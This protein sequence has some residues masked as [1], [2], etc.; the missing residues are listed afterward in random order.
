MIRTSRNSWKKGRKRRVG[1]LEH[2]LPNLTPTLLSLAGTHLLQA[3]GVQLGFVDDFD[4]NLEVK[5]AGEG[6]GTPTQITW[7]VLPLPQLTEKPQPGPFLVDR[8]LGL[9]TFAHAVPTVP[10]ATLTF[11]RKYSYSAVRL[12]GAAPGACVSV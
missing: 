10:N 4:G 3:A 9:R 1:G 2:P 11:I 5:E 8:D 12:D 6:Q 7:D